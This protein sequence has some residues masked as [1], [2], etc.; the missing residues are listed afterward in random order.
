LVDGDGEKD[1]NGTLCEEG[2]QAESVSKSAAGTSAVSA[3]F[4]AANTE[5]VFELLN[6]LSRTAEADKGGDIGVESGNPGDSTSKIG[7]DVG[8]GC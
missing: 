3:S 2:R 8:G 6:E 5:D 7:L 1:G 4:R